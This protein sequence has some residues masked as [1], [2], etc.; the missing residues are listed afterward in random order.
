VL[1]DGLES[2]ICSHPSRR[3]PDPAHP[4][5]YW[6]VRAARHRPGDAKLMALLAAWL[7]LPQALLAFGIGLFS[8]RWPPSSTGCPVSAAGVGKLAMSKLPLEHSSASA[9]R[10]QPMGQ[11]ILAVYLRWAGL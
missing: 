1:S 10:Q 11:P 3:R 5:G 8:A 6:L 9:H 2:T 7:G 4:L